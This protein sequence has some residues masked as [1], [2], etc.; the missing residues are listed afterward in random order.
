MLDGGSAYKV[1]RKRAG[2]NSTVRAC[3]ATAGCK[4]GMLRKALVK[5]DMNCL[6]GSF[7]PW[8]T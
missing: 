8:A 6:S 5:W 1:L 2:L 4:F 7:H 3:M